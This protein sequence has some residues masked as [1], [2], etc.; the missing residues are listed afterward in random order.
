M[1]LFSQPGGCCT[2]V[3]LPHTCLAMRR[4][5]LPVKAR[6]QQQPLLLCPAA[7]FSGVPRSREQSQSGRSMHLHTLPASETHLM[8]ICARHCT[9]YCC[10]SKGTLPAQRLFCRESLW[11]LQITLLQYCLQ[12]SRPLQHFL[13]ICSVRNKTSELPVI[14]NS[15]FPQRYWVWQ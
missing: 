10:L 3:R 14:Y 6:A 7:S 11:P 1:L 12:W 4:H 2:H 13:T 8:W 15:S 9:I 5:H